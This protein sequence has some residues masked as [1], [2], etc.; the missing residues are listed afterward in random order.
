VVRVFTKD[1]TAHTVTAASVLSMKMIN[2][3]RPRYI[4]MV[5]IVAGI[6]G[7]GNYGDILV[8]DHSWDYGSGKIIYDEESKK[9]IFLS[10]PRPIMLTPEIRV[11]FE[12]KS[13]EYIDTIQRSCKLIKPENPRAK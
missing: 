4:V 6:K 8:I 9:T 1:L 2:R 12:E 10:D 13:E 7:K 3:F 11:I 5:G